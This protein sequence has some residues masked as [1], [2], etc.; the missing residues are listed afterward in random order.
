M[1]SDLPKLLGTSFKLKFM[2]SFES[3]I[4]EISFTVAFIKKD[5]P[6]PPPTDVPTTPQP[7]KPTEPQEKEKEKEKEKPK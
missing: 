2:A 1:N 3:L 5:D 7:E 4:K 6:K